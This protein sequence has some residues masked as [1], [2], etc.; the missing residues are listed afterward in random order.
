MSKFE[1]KCHPD[2]EEHVYFGEKA[3]ETTWMVGILHGREKDTQERLKRGRQAVW[4]VRK[5]LMKTRLSRKTQ[6]AIVE[7]DV[8]SSVLFD[9]SIR[10][11]R[12]S[13]V[14]KLQRVIDEAYRHIWSRRNRGSIKHQM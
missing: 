12:I 4:K 9:Y 5:R 8:E 14:T 11:W 13:E 2:K 6:A 7:T 10:P 1:G 3:N